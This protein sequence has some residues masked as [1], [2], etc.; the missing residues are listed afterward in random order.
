ML[1]EVERVQW[2]EEDLRAAAAIAHRAVT[3]T[4]LVKWCIALAVMACVAEYCRLED[5]EKWS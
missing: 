1:G 4:P 5:E 2:E 3:V